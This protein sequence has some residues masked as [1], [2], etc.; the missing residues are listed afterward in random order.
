MADGRGWPLSLRDLI[1]RRPPS[2]WF[3]LHDVGVQFPEDVHQLLIANF[4][5]NYHRVLQSRVAETLTALATFGIPS[6]SELTHLYANYGPGSVSGWYELQ[7]IDGLEAATKYA[8]NELEVPESYIALTSIEGQ[9]ITLYD[10]R[11]AFVYDVEFGQFEA[12]SAGQLEPVANSISE[13]VV[14]CANHDANETS[15]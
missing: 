2:G 14:W 11:S 1:R 15:E 8:W 3:L 12:L 6:Q 10:R 9:G 7:E 4:H 13:F 5:P